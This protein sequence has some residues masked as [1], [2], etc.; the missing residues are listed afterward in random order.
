MDGRARCAWCAARLVSRNAKRRFCSRLCF[1]QAQ[2]D[3]VKDRR[4][5]YRHC[6]VCGGEYRYTYSKQRTCGR[7]CGAVLSARTWPR[8]RVSY[9]SCP[10]CTAIFVRRAGRGACS[11]ACSAEMKRRLDQAYNATRLR[12]ERTC[13]CG[14]DLPS[15]RRYRCDSCL[16]TARRRRKQCERRQARAR[17]A[18]T[19]RERYTLDEIAKRDGYRCGLCHRKVSMAKAVPH[20]RAPTIDHLIPLD[21]GGEDTRA[22]VHLACFYCNSVKGN[23]GGGEQLALLG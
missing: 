11:V 4:L 21:C 17:R 22:N 18:G 9:G 1:G 7:A 19:K 8:S 13:P 14:A 16:T 5:T 3:R 2:A 20:P 12:P 15:A 6:E 23:R 10:V